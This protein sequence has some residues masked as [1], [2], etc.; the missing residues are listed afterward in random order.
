[1]H[2]FGCDKSLCSIVCYLSSLRK[3]LTRLSSC[4]TFPISI[5]EASF[6]SCAQSPQAVAHLNDD[7]HGGKVGPISSSVVSETQLKVQ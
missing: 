3:S 4:V 5:I 1:M 6:Y 2:S 7:L